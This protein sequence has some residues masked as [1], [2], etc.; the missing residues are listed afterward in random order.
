[1]IRLEEASLGT[2]YVRFHQSFDEIT[3]N[4][5]KVNTVHD[6]T[7]SIW[8]IINEWVR[9]AQAIRIRRAPDNDNIPLI[10][11]THEIMAG[12][13]VHRRAHQ[14]MKPYQGSLL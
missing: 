7:Q 13:W 4:G 10:N 14:A 8:S 2:N 3:L 9:R 1:M 5:L 11:T 12:A 6:Y